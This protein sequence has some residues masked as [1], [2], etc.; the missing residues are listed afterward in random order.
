MREENRVF[1]LLKMIHFGSKF[2]MYGCMKDMCAKKNHNNKFFRRLLFGGKQKC[3]ISR[4]LCKWFCLSKCTRCEHWHGK[5]SKSIFPTNK[6]HETVFWIHG[7]IHPRQS[8]QTT[9]NTESQSKSNV[10]AS[11][12]RK[13]DWYTRT[14]THIYMRTQP[15]SISRVF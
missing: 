4:T 7:I 8:A 6:K 3:R 2:V 15:H 1:F 11:K 12:A 13:L 5:P 10:L 9:S 14:H